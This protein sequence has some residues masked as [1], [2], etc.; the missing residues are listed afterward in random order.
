MEQEGSGSSGEQPT[1]DYYHVLDVD[2]DASGSGV[3]AHSLY[4]VAHSTSAPSSFSLSALPS[5]PHYRLPQ[6]AR[7]AASTAS[8]R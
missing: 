7:Y 6:R 1:I 2:Y 8:S 3:C 5:L 4:C